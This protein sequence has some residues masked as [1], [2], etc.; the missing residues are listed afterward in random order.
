M[1]LI[2]I[3]SDGTLDT[4]FDTD[5]RLSI[6]SG[7][8]WLHTNVTGISILEDSGEVWLSGINGFDEE[9]DNRYASFKYRMDDG[10]PT[11]GYT[12]LAKDSGSG[13]YLTPGRSIVTRDGNLVL[14]ASYKTSAVCSGTCELNASIASFNSNGNANEDFGASPDGIRNFD[15]QSGTTSANVFTSGVETFSGRILAV[16]DYNNYSD[17]LISCHDANGAQ[18]NAC[19]R[20]GSVNHRNFHLGGTEEGISSVAMDSRGRFVVG[21]YT[22]LTGGNGIDFAIRRMWP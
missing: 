3:A 12:T 21:G 10:T 18:S 16:G 13:S 5:G 11:T 2:K 15:L 9:N 1:G 7:T 14:F 6:D 17:W 8:S 22:D 19:S 20:S 4:T